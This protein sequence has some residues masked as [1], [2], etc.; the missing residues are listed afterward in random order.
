MQERYRTITTAYYRGAMGFLVMYDVT[1]EESFSAV[2]DWCT[3]INTYSWDNAQVTDRSLLFL[4]ELAIGYAAKLLIGE[5]VNCA[6]GSPFY[7]VPMAYRSCLWATS[8]TW[9][10]SAP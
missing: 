6:A 7:K 9:W 8:A 5:A 1:N 3:Q 2:Q 10:R 4:L